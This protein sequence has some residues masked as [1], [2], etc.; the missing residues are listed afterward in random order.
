MVTGFSDRVDLGSFGD[1]ESDRT[2]VMRVYLTDER[3]EPASLPELRWRIGY[4]LSLVTMAVAVFLLYRF[5]KR[6]GWLGG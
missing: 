3:V 1:I 2:V 4:P 5:F 6:I